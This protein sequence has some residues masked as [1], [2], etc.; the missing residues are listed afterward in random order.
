MSLDEAAA[1]RRYLFAR[2]AV[3]TAQL[4]QEQAFAEL[5]VA[6]AEGDAAN[7]SPATLGRRASQFVRRV[8][9]WGG[10]PSPG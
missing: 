2:E 7:P 8:L 6:R 10:P 9:R 1:E 3:D 4:E 5:A